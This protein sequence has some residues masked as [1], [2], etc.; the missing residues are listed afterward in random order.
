MRET[1][2]TSQRKA[3]AVRPCGLHEAERLRG[4]RAWALSDAPSAFRQTAAEH[5][6]ITPEVW[7]HFL[8]RR[9]AAGDAPL[10]AET[11]GEWVGMV[12]AAMTENGDGGI[13]GMWVCP[14]ARGKGIGRALLNAAL[15]WFQSHDVCRV[16]LAAARANEPALALARSVGFGPT[17]RKHVLRPGIELEELELELPPR[18]RRA[19]GEA[20]APT[21]G[22]EG[23][24]G[25][26]A[27][28]SFLIG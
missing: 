24:V 15:A 4:M 14:E 12:F 28:G 23:E 18:S 13:A 20:A 26:S 6:G 2:L 27:R 16:F 21:P 9:L 1:D 22:P 25:S 8:E 19:L 3:V 11:D 5:E 17:G 10:V 7:R